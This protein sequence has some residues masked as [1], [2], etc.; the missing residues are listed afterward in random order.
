M[1][2]RIGSDGE[3]SLHDLILAAEGIDTFLD[4]LAI[5]AADTVG[6]ASG[7]GI[8]LVSADRATTVSSS[9]ERTS[10]LDEIQYSEG[11]GPGLHAARTGETVLM[12]DLYGDRRWPAYRDQARALG[13]CSSLSLPLDLADAEASG[14]L[15]YYVFEPHTFAGDEVE[16]LSQFRDEMSRA[17]NL[18]LRH[19]RLTRQTDHLHAAMASRRII[20]QA[21]GIIMAQNRC[22]AEQAFVVLRR[23]SNNRNIKIQLLAEDLIR[24]ITGAEPNRDTNWR[25]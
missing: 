23:A 19:D 1:Q 13:L 4:R 14:A 16:Q 20:D 21:L 25:Q 17:L 15:N 3:M 9:D 22:S 2:H 18:A 7:C 8:T 5:L 10:E 6:G 24:N 12:D 11:S